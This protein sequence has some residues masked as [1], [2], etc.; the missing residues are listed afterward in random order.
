MAQDNQRRVFVM[1]KNRTDPWLT[2]GGAHQVSLDSDAHTTLHR[3][4]PVPRRGSVVDHRVVGSRIRTMTIEVRAYRPGDEHALLAAHNRQFAAADGV[5]SMAHW[6]WKYLD[7]PTGQVHIVVAEHAQ[8][9]I[10]GCYVTL[11]V[12]VQVEGRAT[13]AGQPVD[14]FV[15]P[16]FRRAGKR[17]GLFV[18]CAQL[19][20]ERFGG[21]APGQNAFHYGWAVPNWRIG[22][23]YLGY[24]RI[25]DWDFL[26]RECGGGLPDRAL[27]AGLELLPVARCGPDHDALWAALAPT[28]PIAIVRDARYLNWRYLDAHDR[29]YRLF[30]CRERTTG[31]LRGL[32]VF[33]ANDFLVPNAAYLVDWLCPVDDHEC[34]DAMLGHVE[35]LAVAG[36]S[37]VIATLFEKLD[38]RFLLF[39]R[40]GYLVHATTYFTGV[41]SF[42]GH[43]GLFY[44]QGWY[45]T[46]GDSDLV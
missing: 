34:T 18:H 15:L 42:D 3:T 40:R 29:A 5:R 21:T 2:P 16:E 36:G 19:H 1:A 28:F 43:D 41:V 33:T 4:W 44:R 39:Q 8:Q 22:Q 46:P 27:P 38:P 26:F 25:R 30:E 12:P 23:K 13:I 14:L 11:P 6:R 10:V 31:R 7:N 35:R 37:S 32:C 24:E 20:Y 17:P 9:G 45:Q